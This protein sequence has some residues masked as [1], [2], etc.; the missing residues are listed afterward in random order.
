MLGTHLKIMTTKNNKNV[1]DL[2]KRLITHSKSANALNEKV[3]NLIIEDMITLYKQN[4][5]AYG[6]GIM[7]FNVVDPSRSNFTTLE[8]FKNDIAIAEE[9]CEDDLAT[10][11][12]RSVQVAEKC[13]QTQ[14]AVVLLTDGYDL[15]LFA[16]DLEEAVS[17]INNLFN[18]AIF[19]L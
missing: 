18:R 10:F 1:Q 17:N 13:Y 2:M 5:E 14:K 6:P 7:V 16:V 15:K 3:T 12:Q 4:C 11:L 8:D 19:E 9:N